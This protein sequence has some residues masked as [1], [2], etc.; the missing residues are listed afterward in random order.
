M[1]KN[2]T[3]QSETLENNSKLNAIENQNNQQQQQQVQ[4]QPHYQ[5]A[6]QPHA[7]F[8][9]AQPGPYVT[10]A[11]LIANNTTVNSNNNNLI[12]HTPNGVVHHM[13]TAPPQFYYYYHNPTANH[14]SLINNANI[15][16]SN[17]QQ[18]I[19]SA[20]YQ[21][22]HSQH[23]NLI[24]TVQHQHPNNQQQ[25]QSQQ[26]NIALNPIGSFN[27]S[28]SNHLSTYPIQLQQTQTIMHSNLQPFMT[29]VPP[30]PLPIYA[31]QHQQQTNNL[32]Y[33]LPMQTNQQLIIPIQQPQ[34]TSIQTSGTTGVLPPT[35]QQQILGHQNITNTIPLLQVPPPINYHTP[36]A[37]P[38]TGPIQSLQ[39]QTIPVLP[40]SQIHMQNMQKIVQSPHNSSNNEKL[41]Y[42]QNQQQ[43]KPMH[44]HN[45]NL[46]KFS[47]HQNSTNKPGNELV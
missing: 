9:L 45:H 37:V 16:P 18:H 21:M 19:P 25:Q 13:N 47:K 5:P 30:Q 33:Q 32:G 24:Q 31:T 11:A 38:M 14:P 23:P 41:Q 43:Q 28:Q 2:L 29:G 10:N 35:S 1:R 36:M 46:Q 15:T 26:T 39:Q 12:N 4:H 42:N 17:Q 40:S 34:Q 8:Y 44:H 22:H 6:L 20:N 3:F 27:M 7:Y